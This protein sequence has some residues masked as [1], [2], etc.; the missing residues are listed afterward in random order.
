MKKSIIPVKGDILNEND[1]VPL[2]FNPDHF[3][4]KSF[5]DMKTIDKKTKDYYMSEM[6]K[7][8][9]FPIICTKATSFLPL[10]HDC[11]LVPGAWIYCL[12]PEGETGLNFALYKW[13]EKDNPDYI[14]GWC[15]INLDA[16][17]G[18]CRLVP[19]PVT[20]DENV[21]VVTDEENINKILK[22]KK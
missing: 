9:K 8:L 22:N 18:L 16:S 6:L 5:V 7:E 14:K 2:R 21:I 17:T 11:N 19:H 10:T 1:S 4:H 12:I 3:K 13:R 20:T 15:Y